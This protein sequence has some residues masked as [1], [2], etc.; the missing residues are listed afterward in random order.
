[1]LAIKCSLNDNAPAPPDR[2]IKTEAVE[3]QKFTSSSLST[4][5][6][7]NMCCPLNASYQP[8]TSQVVHLEGLQLT[9]A[10]YAA[11]FLVL[12]IRDRIRHGRHFTFKCQNLALTLVSESVTGAVVTKKNPYG[13]LG[14]WM[15]ILITDD[16]IDVMLESFQELVGGIR[17]MTLPKEYDWPDKNLKIIID[18]PEQQ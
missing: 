6:S 12:A 3:D 2:F 18:N 15:Q 16:L 17:T 4:N 5:N 11:K 7:L 1:M 10:P 9:L 14:Y 13:V 8:N